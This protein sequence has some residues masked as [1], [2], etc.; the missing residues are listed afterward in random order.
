MKEE[1][2]EVYSDRT[3]HA[4]MKHPRRNSPGSLMQGDTLYALC[5]DAD[6]IADMIKSNGDM[7][8]YQEM[9][10]LRNKLW[11]RL[12]HYKN[13]LIEHDIDLPFSER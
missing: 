4:V 9:N 2:V 3:N 6:R 1:N 11:E 12:N 8:T 10:A 13:T 7:Q 5:K